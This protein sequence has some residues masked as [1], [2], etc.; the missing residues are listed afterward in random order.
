[1]KIRKNDLPKKNFKLENYLR[2]LTNAIKNNKTGNY[3][4]CGLENEMVFKIFLDALEQAGLIIKTEK[5]TNNIDLSNYSVVNN[6]DI[7]INNNTIVNNEN[8]II[9]N[10]NIIINNFNYD[11]KTNNWFANYVI[12]LLPMGIEILRLVFN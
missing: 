11:K 9:N 6:R 8:M 7:E 3:K 12:P 2:S 4:D 5:N 10:G 1:M